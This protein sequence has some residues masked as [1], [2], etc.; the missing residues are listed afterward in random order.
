MNMIPKGPIECGFG[1]RVIRVVNCY[2]SVAG[3]R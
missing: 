3:W 1:I 2:G